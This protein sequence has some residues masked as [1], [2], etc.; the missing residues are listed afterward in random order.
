MQ[1]DIIYPDIFSRRKSSRYSELFLIS[2]Y[3]CVSE[4]L[5]N[6]YG[7]PL[8]TTKLLVN[9]LTKP[10]GRNEF[11]L[12]QTYYMHQHTFYILVGL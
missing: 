4:K 7:H 3:H 11:C 12:E 6:T 10:F 8:L 9:K 1:T 2:Q 5:N